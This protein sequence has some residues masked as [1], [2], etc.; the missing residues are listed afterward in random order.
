MH[1]CV[2]HSCGFVVVGFSITNGIFY[3]NI[4]C[5]LFLL[6]HRKLLSSSRAIL[7]FGIRSLLLTKI[8]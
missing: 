7:D 6:L 8:L 4:F 1:V 5:E 2:Y 3:S